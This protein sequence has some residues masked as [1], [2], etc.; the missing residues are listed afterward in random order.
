MLATQ[1]VCV[2]IYSV[3]FMLS[4]DNLHTNFCEQYEA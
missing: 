3:C 4:I 1:I 2:E